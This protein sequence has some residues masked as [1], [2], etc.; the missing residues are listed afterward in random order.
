MVL[1]SVTRKYAYLLTGE[2]LDTIG[3]SPE[4]NLESLSIVSAGRS[5]PNVSK[6]RWGRPLNIVECPHHAL[7]T[8]S[9]HA[10]RIPLL[11]HSR[12]PSL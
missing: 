8:A 4:E 9:S 2:S 10:R 3:F 5:I 6:D 7:N 11:S 1:R 12:H